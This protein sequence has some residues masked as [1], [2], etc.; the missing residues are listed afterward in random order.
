VHFFR[1]RGLSKE[2]CEQKS[3]LAGR[4]RRKQS[5]F[6]PQRKRGKRPFGEWMPVPLERRASPSEVSAK[7]NGLP[8][9]HHG[10]P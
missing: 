7:K 5:P 6:A 3:I 4:Q 9:F 1:N 8:G 2:L 10:R